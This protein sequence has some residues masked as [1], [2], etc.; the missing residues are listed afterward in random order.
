MTEFSGKRLVYSNQVRSGK[1][2]HGKVFE[3]FPFTAEPKES[4]PCTGGADEEAGSLEMK[5]E[6][7]ESGIEIMWFQKKS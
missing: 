4:W 5:K 7:Y 3:I 6:I 2:I 1:R